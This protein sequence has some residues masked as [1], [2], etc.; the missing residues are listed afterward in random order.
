MGDETK[1]TEAEAKVG[2]MEI[3]GPDL[4]VIL[5]HFLDDMRDKYVG[6]SI[7]D[8][9]LAMSDD[10]G[11]RIR[12]LDRATKNAQNAASIDT[13]LE[14]L[15]R[16]LNRIKGDGFDDCDDFY[17]NPEDG[18]GLRWIDHDKVMHLTGRVLDAIAPLPDA[19]QSDDD[20]D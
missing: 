4:A 12:A 8:S 16:R 13:I 10:L 6:R 1:T 11:T 7:Y 2:V 9:E 3:W 15:K 20:D 5:F 18:T 19:P 14:R 17:D